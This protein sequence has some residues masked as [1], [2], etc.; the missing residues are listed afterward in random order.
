MEYVRHNGD[1]VILSSINSEAH[2]KN[3]DSDDS[4]MHDHTPEV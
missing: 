1:S 4:C 2:R 3:Q